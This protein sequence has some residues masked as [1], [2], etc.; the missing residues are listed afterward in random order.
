MDF[1][2]S[3]VDILVCTAEMIKCCL[4]EAASPAE[5][6]RGILLHL[7]AW[8]WCNI[9]VARE[10]NES[11]GNSFISFDVWWIWQFSI[12]WFT[13]LAELRAACKAGQGS[14]NFTVETHFRMLFHNS[15]RAPGSALSC[16]RLHLGSWLRSRTYHSAAAKS[17]SLLRLQK[18][19]KHPHTKWTEILFQEDSCVVTSSLSANDTAPGSGPAQEHQLG[20]LESCWPQGSPRA[21]EKSFPEVCSYS[22]LS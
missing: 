2:Q 16:S 11:H 13:S 20:W 8:L 1:S 15:S 22:L 10:H 21:L 7:T 6:L 19:K 17:V 4:A 14:H 12:T 3:F 9:S 18:W 5:E